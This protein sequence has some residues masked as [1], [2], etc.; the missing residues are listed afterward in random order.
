MTQIEDC[1]V[2]SS[3]TETEIVKI[4]NS[5][6]ESMVS[7]GTTVVRCNLSAL[8]D[9]D[10]DE[11]DVKSELEEQNMPRIL[12]FSVKKMDNLNRN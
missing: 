12:D 11:M 6:A 4:P 10:L 7:K 9:A 8:G 2:I 3:G 5:S 1:E